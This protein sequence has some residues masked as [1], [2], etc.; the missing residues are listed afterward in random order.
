MANKLIA[1]IVQILILSSSY[2]HGVRSIQTGHSV[3]EHMHR[4]R[5][6]RKVRDLVG[7]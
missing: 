3:R 2:P 6:T 4:V 7:E 1:P 5:I